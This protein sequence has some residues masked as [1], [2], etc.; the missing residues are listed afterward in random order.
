EAG[1]NALEPDIMKFSDKAAFGGHYINTY[2]STSKLFVYHDDV[3]ITTHMPSTVEEYFTYIHDLI[4]KQGK[5][6]AL[7]TI[8][9]K[10]P[11]Y[12]F[13][14]QLVTA[15]HSIFNTNDAQR[16]WI[17]YN[18]GPTDPNDAGA[19]GFF[20]DVGPLLNDH[21]GISIDGTSDPDGVYSAL[22]KVTR[23]GN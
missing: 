21:E 11:A 20:T 22:A 6:I 18:C 13:G 23:N 10:S 16:P 8:D 4:Y 7:L 2:A 14:P 3:L 15:I 12:K 1:A 19:K 9:V 17:I 5:N